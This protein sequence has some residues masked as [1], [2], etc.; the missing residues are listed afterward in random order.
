MSNATNN[1]QSI[2]DLSR[3][4]LIAREDN[5]YESVRAAYPNDEADGWLSRTEAVKEARTEIM[6]ARSKLVVRL[7]IDAIICIVGISL[8]KMSWIT[9]VALL[10]YALSI[11]FIDIH[12]YV[13]SVENARRE[14]LKSL[15]KIPVSDSSANSFP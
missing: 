5:L 7:T 9:S 12:S 15:E 3:F 10:G 8:T 13:S 6:R 11:I 14:M 4:L 1:S 2:N